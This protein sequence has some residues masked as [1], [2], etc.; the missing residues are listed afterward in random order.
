MPTDVHFNCITSNP[1]AEHATIPYTCEAS[2][3]K[4]PSTVSIK[5]N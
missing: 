1:K 2:K 5:S 4:R 3:L